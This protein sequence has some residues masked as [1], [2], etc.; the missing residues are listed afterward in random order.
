[1]RLGGA[2]GA[3][4]GRLLRRLVDEGI[5]GGEDALHGR[6]TV[7]DL[8]RSNQVS[9]VAVDARP[10]AVVKRSQTEVDDA[11]DLDPMGAEVAAYRWLAGA[12]A[13][14]RLAPVMI[15][16]L[17]EEGAIITEPVVD[18]VSLHDEMLRP[19]G[20]PESLI[21]GLGSSLGIL[22][23]AFVDVDSLHPRRPWILG[24]PS[25][26]VPAAIAARPSIKAILDRICAHAAV[27]SAIQ[28]LGSTWKPRAAIHGD[29][30]FDNVLVTSTTPVD[31]HQRPEQRL[32]LIDW[33]LAG[34]GEPV[35]D[36][37]GVVDGLLMPRLLGTFGDS[38]WDQARVE[39]LAAPA[40]A[41]H[42]G[43]AGA[44]LSPDSAALVTAVV[45]RLAQTSLQ[46]A[47]MAISE[48]RDTTSAGVSTVLTVAER[49]ADDLASNLAEQPRR[50][51]AA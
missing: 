11:D 33:E 26:Q 28:W 44:A 41:S 42:R 1:M 7:T 29:V 45:V 34:L 6:V 2:G 17:P 51:V 23:G 12:P 14:A 31:L 32:W 25:G 50:A 24:V 47:A 4:P 9:L 39:H 16:A 27:V 40:L 35:W 15:A 20:S 3:S 43:A 10:A 38:R 21:V 13:T 18:A 49:L 36:L 22:H 48:P 46:L 8:S 5:V 37:A 30:K 19:G